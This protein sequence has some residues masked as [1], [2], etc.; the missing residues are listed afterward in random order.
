MGD[1]S[2]MGAGRRGRKVSLW[3]LGVAGTVALATLAVQAAGAGTGGAATA[4]APGKPTTVVATAHAGSATVTWTAAPT[5]G[6]P[7]SGYTVT[8]APT[9]KHCTTTGALS[10]T[11]T[12]LANGDTYTFTVKATNGQGTGPT[13]TPSTPVTPVTVPG[14]PTA[15]HATAGNAT[16]KVTWSA[17]PDNGSTITEYTVTSEPTLKTCTSTGA[18]HCTVNALTN[19]TAY[20]FTVIATNGYGTSQPSTPSSPVTPASPPTAAPTGLDAV[21]GNQ[22][23]AATW[24]AVPGSDDGGAPITGYTLQAEVNTKVKKTATVG[25]TATS[26]TVGTLVNG[27]SYRLTVAA[28]NS[29]GTGPPATSGE[30]VPS[31]VPGK[32]ANVTAQ[33]ADGAALV[34]WTP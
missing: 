16:A 32:P 21:A 11:V 12:G 28:F 13:S 7:I 24:H 2:R 26:G 8:S 4:S 27:T 31:A 29:A 3:R 18:L 5:H 6:S 19:G 22:E 23:I 10:C 34:L 25:A 20:T 30:V 1:V 9:A 33:A 15:V 17:P 14:P